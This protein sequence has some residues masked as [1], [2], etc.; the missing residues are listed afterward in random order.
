[1]R[2]YQ[3]P[4]RQRASG[5]FALRRPPQPPDRRLPPE[6]GGAAGGTHAHEHGVS[7]ARW[8]GTGITGPASHTS[9]PAA[10][11]ACRTVPTLQG[12][13]AACANRGSSC[14]ANRDK[15]RFFLLTT[16]PPFQGASFW[17]RHQPRSGSCSGGPYFFPLGHACA[18]KPGSGFPGGGFNWDRQY[19][20]T[21]VHHRVRPSRYNF[22]MYVV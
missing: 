22:H 18:G 8:A 1:M 3:P 13:R 12:P 16:I 6:R 19:T 20:R 7:G 4:L 2:I 9:C 21:A 14:A 15:K 5:G 17:Q 11:G 10:Q